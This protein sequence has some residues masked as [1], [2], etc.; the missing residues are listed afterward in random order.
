MTRRLQGRVKQNG[1]KPLLGVTMTWFDLTFIDVIGRIGFDCV[2]F[3][4]EHSHIT[5]TDTHQMCQMARGHDLIKIV[6]VPG[7]GRD[8]ITKTLECDPDVIICPITDTVND[9]E[10]LVEHSRYRPFGQRGMYSAL[11]SAN[12]GIGGLSAEK[13]EELDQQLSIYGQIESATAV[14]NLDDMCKV[15]GID[16]F[17]IGRFDL[18]ADLGIPTQ[19]NHPDVMKLVDQSVEIIRRNGKEVALLGGPAELPAFVEMGAAFVMITNQTALIR[20]SAISVLEKCG[21]TLN[22]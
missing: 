22:S 12:Y 5:T 7:T 10:Q 8:W 2:W 19:M 6:R 4:Q 16:G 18:S 13:F 15:E 1:G 14:E 11:A 17:V 20:D 9:L 21:R 3:D